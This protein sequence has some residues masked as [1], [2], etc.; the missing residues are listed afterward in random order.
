MATAYRMIAVGLVV[1]MIGAAVAAFT[2]WRVAVPFV[3]GPTIAV[4]YAVVIYRY[5]NAKI[6]LRSTPAPVWVRGWCRPP[7]GCNYAVFDSEPDEGT[8]PELVVRLPIKRAMATGPAWLCLTINRDAAVLFDDQ[9]NFLGAG[10]VL[11]SGR[12][13]TVYPRRD[14]PPGKHVMQPPKDFL[15][16]GG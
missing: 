15:P 10:R 13:S 6:A 3:I 14:E 4:L 7:D 1:T 5:S 12:A 9:G 2:T 8:E 11:A 16:P